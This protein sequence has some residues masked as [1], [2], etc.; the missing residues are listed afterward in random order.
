MAACRDD[1]F[2][3]LPATHESQGGEVVLV[4]GGGVCIQTCLGAKNQIFYIQ[5]L[6]TLQKGL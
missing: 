2:S 4:G 1:F 5:T 6:L 3:L